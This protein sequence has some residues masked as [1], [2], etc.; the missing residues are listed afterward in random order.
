MSR[1]DRGSGVITNAFQQSGRVRPE[2]K[3]VISNTAFVEVDVD[4]DGSL[5][6]K[7]FL[8]TSEAQRNPGGLDDCTHINSTVSPLESKW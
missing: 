4:K 1:T 3:E 7:F 2:G 8:K 5:M 6:G